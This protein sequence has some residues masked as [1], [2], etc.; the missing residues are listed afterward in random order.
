M[1]TRMPERAE[2]ARFD[3]HAARVKSFVMEDCERGAGEVFCVHPNVYP[4]LKRHDWGPVLPNLR[5]VVLND[6]MCVV[7]CPA[8]LEANKPAKPGQNRPGQAEP[9]KVGL[10]WLMAWLSFEAG[11]AKPVK[12]WLHW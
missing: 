12:P 3:H 9:V 5:R 6:W 7:M 1:I 4:I 8:W 11:Q 2:W 10:G